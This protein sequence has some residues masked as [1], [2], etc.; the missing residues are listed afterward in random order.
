MSLRI[1]TGGNVD[2]G[3]STLTACLFG[4]IDDGRGAA[5]ATLFQHP[6]EKESGR[7]STVTIRE[8]RIGDRHVVVGDL[9]GHEKYFKT[10]ISG[11]VGL[12]TDYVFVVVAA[13][14]GVTSITK[15]HFKCAACMNLPIIVV[16][17]KIDLAPKNI[18]K[19]TYQ[20]IY[21]LCKNHN[22][23]R[24]RITSTDVNENVI[25]SCVARAVVPVVSL[26]CVTR[27]CMDHFYAL[28]EKLPVWRTYDLETSCA[29]QIESIFHVNG[30]GIVVGGVCIR[31]TIPSNTWAYLG[32][33]KQGEYKRVRV[34]S[35]FTED[36][37]SG[38]I[39]AGQYGTLAI[40]KKGLKRK[41]ISKGM[42]LTTDPKAVAV[43]EIEARIFVLHHATTIKIGYKPIVHCRTLKRAAQVVDMNK[44]L[45]RSGDYAKVKLRFDVPVFVLPGDHFVFRESRSKG[46]GK[47]I[48][49]H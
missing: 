45:V 24:Y 37:D 23:Q 4:E 49:V 31:G 14:R 32:P 26:S 2:A 8:G 30:V 34:K 12:M 41:H 27:A 21:H 6:H 7:T 9:P 18:L 39:E 15:E 1:A 16:V 28:F 42:V 13:N 46:V 29:I 11:L 43:R 47:I 48:H 20:Q 40:V 22:R 38:N 25:A 10:T 17:S 35:I 5:R 44:L 19:E 3:K 36:V 33:F